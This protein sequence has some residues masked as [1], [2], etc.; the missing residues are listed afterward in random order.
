M[1]AKSDQE[2]RVELITINSL[3]LILSLIFYYSLDCHI[4][5][6]SSRSKKRE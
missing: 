6:G 1:S 4:F 5:E 3:D 2:K